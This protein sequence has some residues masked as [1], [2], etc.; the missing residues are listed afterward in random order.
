MN[1]HKSL[2][3]VSAIEFEINR[4]IINS[5]R[6]FNDPQN[7]AR[8]SKCAVISQSPATNKPKNRLDSD[9]DGSIRRANDTNKQICKKNKLDTENESSD[10]FLQGGDNTPA[11]VSQSQ[12]TNKRKNRFDSK[13]DGSIRWPKDTNKQKCTKNKL[14]LE[15]GCSGPSLQVSQCL[16]TN[17]E[18]FI[19]KAKDMIENEINGKKLESSDN[20]T[21]IE[22]VKFPKQN[23]KEAKTCYGEFKFWL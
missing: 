17:H 6:F 9:K 4:G 8:N 7:P 11:V 1:P 20:S 2:E 14:D 15:N 13:K 10:T 12:A 3:A 18:V 23:K 16:A 22:L 5:N 21:T 19:R